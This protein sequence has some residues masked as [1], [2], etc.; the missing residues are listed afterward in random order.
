MFAMFPKITA[1][2]PPAAALQVLADLP[3]LFVSILLVIIT[4]LTDKPRIEAA[5]SLVPVNYLYSDV[6]SCKIFSALSLIEFPYLRMS[7]IREVFFD[8]LFPLNTDKHSFESN[9]LS[10]ISS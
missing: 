3:L 4:F 5:C 2:A 7:R 6:S 10:L 8:S 1:N 9:P